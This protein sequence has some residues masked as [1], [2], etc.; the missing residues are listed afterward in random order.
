MS[1]LPT[2]VLVLGLA[3]LLTDLSS[4]MIYPL[5]PAFLALTLGAGAVGLGAMEG[6][7]ETTASLLKIASGAIADRAPRRKP[8]VVAG[9][10]LS[11]AARPLIAFALAWPVVMALRLLDR[12]GKGIRT[13]PRDALIADVTAA[14]AR[15]RAYGMH[16]AMDNAGAVVGPL[17]AAGLLAVGVSTRHVFLAAAAPAALV[18]IVL[19]VGVREGPR[20]SPTADREQ[21][22]T[23][24]RHMG[25]RF[26]RLLVVVFVFALANSSDAFL[27]L[28][29][30]DLG[31]APEG[32]ALAW[33]GHN[34]VRTL[35]VYAG[36]TLADRMDRK[37]MLAA[38]WAM[39]V[40]I[41]AALALVETLAAMVALLVVYA[42][43]Y[44]AVEA[45]ERAL[46]ADLAPAERRASA[47]GWYH[48]V[49]GFAALPASL[50]FG[51][52][53]TTCGPRVA[54]A[55]SAAVAAVALIALFAVV[56]EGRRTEEP[57]VTSGS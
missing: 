21:A 38:G 55:T 25:A 45:V 27:L 44:G 6:A 4:E 8:L 42:L 57:R 5:L 50:V 41:Y 33:T 29:L 37:R 39:Y 36:G 1:R 23:A 3:S 14:D 28:R 40:A 47:F 18:V 52:L 15:G 30:S 2:A 31:L 20:H 7:A 53:W 22:R 13:A 56:P 17:V 43:H 9:Y 54:F 49:V 10:A 46:V 19:V 51:V 16:R 35:A 24:S 32:V 48:A 11:G 26:R 12:V 34:V